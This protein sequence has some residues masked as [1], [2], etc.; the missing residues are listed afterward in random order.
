MVCS[1]DD[2]GS[3]AP[4][5]AAPDTEWLHHLRVLVVEDHADTADSLA[6]VLK[7]WGCPVRICRSGVGCL[8]AARAFR[9]HVVLLDLAMPQMD[10]YQVAQ[11]LRGE[12]DVQ[13]AVLIACTGYGREEDRR[14]TR[15]AG[16]DYHL[17]KPAD[18]AQLKK[19]LL[20]IS[21]L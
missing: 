1:H 14:R 16:F 13:G 6:L 2:H 11:C 19:L 18:L 21:R 4:I 3:P 8:E 9:P 7:A 12:E 10:G 20:Q 5:V 15:E 17:T